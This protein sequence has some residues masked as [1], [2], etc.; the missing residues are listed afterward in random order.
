MLFHFSLSRFCSIT[1]VSLVFIPSSMFIL[2]LHVALPNIL[3]TS[4]YF[5]SL[6]DSVSSISIPRSPTRKGLYN[7]NN[8]N[9]SR[10]KRFTYLFLFVFS[11][12]FL[13]AKHFNIVSA[14]TVCWKL[15]PDTLSDLI[16]PSKQLYV[17]KL[18]FSLFYSSLFL[19]HSN[20]AFF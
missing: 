11:F 6:L 9:A 17:L 18:L 7:S 15:C 16:Y 2:V 4:L 5:D 10:A 12:S 14:L 20:L 3:C 19:K 1:L 8:K 13:W